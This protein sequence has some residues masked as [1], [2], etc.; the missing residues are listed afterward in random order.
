MS[1]DDT[2]KEHMDAVR[3]VT[4]ANDL[5][6]LATSTD[7]LNDFNGLKTV[8]LASDIDLNQLTTPGVYSLWLK[9]VKN[10]PL[11]GSDQGSILLVLGPNKDSDWMAQ[12]LLTFY[13]GVYCRADSAHQI[14]IGNTPWKSLEYTVVP[15][16]AQPASGSTQSTQPAASSTTE[17]A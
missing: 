4:G 15:K 2:M 10:S 5:L 6:S 9:P 13:S 17:G 3:K 16:P 1:L 12:L 11:E 8:P 7:L 14:S